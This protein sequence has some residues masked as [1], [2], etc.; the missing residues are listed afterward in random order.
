MWTES[1]RRMAHNI[2]HQQ[3]QTPENHV[4]LAAYL[5]RIAADAMQQPVLAIRLH[6]TAELVDQWA[7]KDPWEPISP[8]NVEELAVALL[9]YA[10]RGDEPHRITGGAA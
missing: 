1:L 2:R 4:A 9:S 5:R 3:V 10:D 7:A 6:A 8:A